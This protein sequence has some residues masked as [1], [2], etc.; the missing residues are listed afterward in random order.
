MGM[1]ECGIKGDIKVIGLSNWENEW[2]YGILT[3]MIKMAGRAGLGVTVSGSVW[4]Y[5]I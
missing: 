3:A 1:K 2:R 4:T 5:L